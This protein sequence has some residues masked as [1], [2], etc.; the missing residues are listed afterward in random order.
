MDTKSLER[1]IRRVVEGNH[2][3]PALAGVTD[4]SDVQLPEEFRNAIKTLES[5]T[6]RPANGKS[7]LQ[8]MTQ[9]WT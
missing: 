8:I 7:I 9:G 6:H 2:G 4:A 3:R 1:V 5:R